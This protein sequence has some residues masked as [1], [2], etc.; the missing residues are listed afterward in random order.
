M[1]HPRLYG[2]FYE[3][4]FKYGSLLK[5]KGF[6]LPEFSKEEYNFGRASY[7]ELAEYYPEV[8]EEIEGFSKA[9]NE[10]PEKL[11]AF[12]LSRGIFETTGQCSVFAW[13]DPNK[14][15]AVIV[16]IN[17]DMLYDF[18]KFTES[19]LIAPKGQYAYI[20]QS[21]MFIGRC[22]GINQ[23]GLSVAIS[24][25]NGTESQPGITFHFVVRK[26]LETCST[27]KDAIKLIER[28][29][30]SAANNFLI[31][32][33]TGDIAVVEA[34]PQ[35]NR[36]RRPDKKENYILITNQFISPEME[37]FD[38]GGVKWSKSLE[39]YDALKDSLKKVEKM[40]IETAKTF[41]SEKKVCLDLRKRKFG[42]IW[43]VVAD[44]STLEVE[45]AEAKPKKTNY[46]NDTRLNWWLEKKSK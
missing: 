24:F 16:G 5:S 37:Q 6:Q 27:T 18:K 23:K 34:A 38:R 41:L 26:I 2:E 35:G 20:G 9:I 4:G 45:R 11:G 32:D 31:A 44:L 13:R 12:L 8:L 17:Y 43:S 10:K 42:T 25:V 36:V 14:E 19:S 30:V 33:K 40:D 21:D 28:T 7:K 3:M 29:K 46:S 39:R 22:D 1:Y 15:G